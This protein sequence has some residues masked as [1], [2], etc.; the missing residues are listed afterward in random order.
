M[1]ATE[2]VEEDDM[3][4]SPNVLFSGD[5]RQRR[6]L[7]RPLFPNTSPDLPLARR[8]HAMVRRLRALHV[9][10]TC[11]AVDIFRDPQLWPQFPALY[12]AWSVDEALAAAVDGCLDSERV[13]AE[14]YAL[15][16]QAGPCRGASFDDS[17]T[18]A[19]SARGMSVRKAQQVQHMV[20]LVHTLLT[21]ACS[22]EDIQDSPWCIVDLGCGR[23]A[24][25]HSLAHQLLRMRLRTPWRVLGVEQDAHLCRRFRQ[26]WQ[27]AGDDESRCEVFQRRVRSAD[28]ILEAVARTRPPSATAAALERLAVIGLHAC[29][30]LTTCALRTMEAAGHSRPQW[31]VSVGC[32]YHRVPLA[33]SPLADADAAFPLSQPMRRRYALTYAPRA[34]GGGALMNR[35][36]L[37]LASA[38]KQSMGRGNRRRAQQFIVAHHHRSLL[39][40]VLHPN[41][42]A[43]PADD[44]S[45]VA[46]K[47][48]RRQLFLRESAPVDEE[49]EEEAAFMR[50]ASAAFDK[51]HRRFDAASAS[52]VYR[53]HEADGRRRVAVLWALSIQVAP[54]IEALVLLDRLF[55]ARECGY[56][57]SIT[58]L[59]P[60]AASPRNQALIAVHP[61]ANMKEGAW[62]PQQQ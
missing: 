33:Q 42:V 27:A 36:S 48:L 53:Q 24:L 39:E 4:L 16:R 6:D 10:H 15:A 3:E 8:I 1:T 45:E 23:G 62:C 57:A 13:A 41:D 19:F 51:L 58:P 20:R 43:T 59:F 31:V 61:S 22:D 28:D 52:S 17:C 34:H 38:D 26:R 5:V 12:R 46:S 49:D 9:V 55:Y 30:D 18:P 37:Y 54:L 47:V 21:Q 25:S 29:G 44:M 11:R 56:H 40:C 60:T 2:E 7:L 32:C 35:S 14:A 50:Y